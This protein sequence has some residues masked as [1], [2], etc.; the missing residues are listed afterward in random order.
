MLRIRKKKDSYE[1]TIR[2]KN[3]CPID[4]LASCIVGTKDDIG[5]SLDQLALNAVAFD[6]VILDTK[7]N[8]HCKNIATEPESSNTED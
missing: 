8:L 4:E 3:T 5:N 6:E 7:G 1:L 2:Y